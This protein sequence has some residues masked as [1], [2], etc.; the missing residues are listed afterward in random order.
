MRADL[1]GIDAGLSL[2]KA[3]RA[4]LSLIS[5]NPAAAAYGLPMLL[6]G[7]LSAIFLKRR[8][9][10]LF[11]RSG[12]GKRQPAIPAHCLLSRQRFILRIKKIH[13]RAESEGFF[14]QEHAM[15]FF[16]YSFL[17]GMIR[18]GADRPIRK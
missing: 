6:S 2:R 16:I 5:A 13:A 18:A 7:A 10:Y 3:G 4:F 11:K 17:A 8:D 15:R 9:F 12:D 14:A 1:P